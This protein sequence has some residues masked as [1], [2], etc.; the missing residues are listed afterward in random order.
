MD[1]TSPGGPGAALLPVRRRRAERTKILV[2]AGAAAAV[3]ALL[4]VVLVAVLPGGSEEEEAAAP[5]SEGISEEETPLGVF[6][7]DVPAADAPA[8]LEPAMLVM[9][10]PEDQRADA[11]V[12]IDDRPQT[13]PVRGAVEYQVEPGRWRVV[14]RREGYQEI[15]EFLSFVPGQD[16]VWKPEFVEQQTGSLQETRTFLSGTVSLE[17]PGGFAPMPEQL[18]SQ[19]FP[20]KDRPEVVLSNEEGTVSVAL[21]RKKGTRLG[22]DEFSKIMETTKSRVQAADASCEWLRSETTVVNGHDGYLFDYRGKGH[23]GRLRAVIIFAALDDGLLGVTFTCDAGLED[24]W[25]PVG[26][27]VIQSV[28]VRP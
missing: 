8:G 22:P 21:G 27:R 5:A 2:V 25:V 28:Q 15:E 12:F 1:L 3:C 19:R 16:R 26:N 18:M 20:S 6:G 13:V 14:V 17:V 7:F 24:Q 4:V 11:A 23:G 10:W 9:D